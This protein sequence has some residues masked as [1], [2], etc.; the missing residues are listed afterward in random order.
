MR[1]FSYSSLKC[2]RRCRYQYLLKYVHGYTQPSS[3]GQIRGSAGHIALATWYV[4]HTREKAIKAAETYITE[5]ELEHGRDLG[6]DW[7]LLEFILER[8][9]D[10]SEQNDNFELIETELRFDLAIGQHQFTGFVDGLVKYQDSLWL[11]EH[12]FLKSIRMKHISIDPQISLYM[13]AMRK[14]DFD[15]AGTFFNL[16]RM[17]KGGIAAK[18]PVVRMQAYRNV[19][20]LEV[21]EKELITQADEMCDFH[22]HGGKVYRNPTQDCTWDCSFY[23]VCLAINDDG[24]A[25]SVLRTFKKKPRVY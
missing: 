20:A 7:E 18:E 21:I 1:K 12:K 5:A 15:V 11:L 17:T 3:I 2:W 8:Y 22:L 19:E 25:D 9:F 23:P 14:L 13:L 24:K 6:K 16:I 10:W 4:D